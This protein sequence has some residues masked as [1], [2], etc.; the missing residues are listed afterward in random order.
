MRHLGFLLLILITAGLGTAAYMQDKN[1]LLKLSTP[2]AKLFI[3]FTII[4]LSKLVTLIGVWLIRRYGKTK[5]KGELKQVTSVYKYIIV[6]ILVLAISILL[7]GVIGPALTSIS[8][9]A[10]GLTLALQK[11]IL[12]I[13]GWFS[14]IT[15]RPFRIGDR[16]DIGGIGGYVHEI[17]LMQTHLSLVEKE[18]AT[19]K[20]VF[21][22]NEQALTQ[23]I[24]NYTRGSPLIWETIKVR[25]P[26][27]V[28]P[29][30]IERKLLK[31]SEQVIG[32][33]MSEAANK[34]NA[35]VK[36]ETR[37]S[38]EFNNVN[39]YVEISVRYL[40]SAK[41]AT[42]TKSEITK[43]IIEELKKELGVTNGKK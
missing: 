29:A 12:N 42:S 17:S 5:E 4:I 13:A 23:P 34:W 38:L 26:V 21:V 35:D 11:P 10:A 36:P 14:I 30:E 28:K 1:S 2:L 32:R 20:V 8:L 7:Y 41:A 33:Q 3:I 37:T 9:L 6:I 24:V 18:E 16:V 31:C 22:P 39:P 15:K 19:G 25:F 43:K 27:S 40:C